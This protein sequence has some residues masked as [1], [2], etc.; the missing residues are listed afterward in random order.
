TTEAGEFLGQSYGLAAGDEGSLVVLDAS[1]IEDI[2][3]TESIH[4]V[5]HRGTVVD[6][7]A[8]LAVG[9][10]KT[11]LAWYAW[12]RVLSMKDREM[13]ILAGALGFLATVIVG[14]RRFRR[15]RKARIALD[16]AATASA[17]AGV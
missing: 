13:L 15:R 12:A 11:E 9:A 7:E 4:L 16:S 2:R 17:G 3:N 10:P 5:I 14:W 6:R 8:L 1:P